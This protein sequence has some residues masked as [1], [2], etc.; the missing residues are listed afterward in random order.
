MR[1]NIEKLI[2]SGITAYRV[3]KETGIPLNT[4][5]RIFS[6][7]A[8]LDNITLKNAEILNNYYK[9]LE[10]IEMNRLFKNVETGTIKSY[11]EW[12]EQEK[13]FCGWL[14]EN[15]SDYEGMSVD[16]ILEKRINSGDMFADLEELTQSYE[17]EEVRFEKDYNGNY[18]YSRVETGMMFSIDKFD[19]Y[20]QA[21][22]YLHSKKE[23]ICEGEGY[24]LS[25]VTRDE[26]D[27]VIDS[28]LLDEINYSQLENE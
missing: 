22:K 23:E 9:K 24:F 16:E 5:T 4:A 20:Y 17:V 12:L 28:E 1:K 7:E 25:L 14:M 21:K 13:T 2:A 3:S 8:N 10:E 19:S 11:K 15:N 18:D 6:G 26:D 27:I